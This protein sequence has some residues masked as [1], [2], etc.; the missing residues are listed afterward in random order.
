MELKPTVVFRPMAAAFYS[1]IKSLQ[2]KIL[3]SRGD[4]ETW[5]RRHTLVQRRW[6]SLMATSTL[7]KRKPGW[8]SSRSAFIWIIM[9]TPRLTA[10]LARL[11]GI[12]KQKAANAKDNSEKK[13]DRLFVPGK[14]WHRLVSVRP[15]MGVKGVWTLWGDVCNWMER[16]SSNPARKLILVQVQAGQRHQRPDSRLVRQWS[17]GNG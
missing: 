13:R 8:K 1:L 11:R 17:N 10:Q 3:Q 15:C 4:R 16:L 12:D 9:C 6:I 5:S 14:T 2:S 7:V